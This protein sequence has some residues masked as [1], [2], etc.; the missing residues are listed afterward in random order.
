M[1]CAIISFI[2]YSW[3]KTFP[4]FII[5]VCAN[6]FI[7]MYFEIKHVS[8]ENIYQLLSVKMFYVEFIFLSFHSFKNDWIL[9][10]QE[11]FVGENSGRKKRKETLQQIT[12]RHYYDSFSIFF[13]A[14]NRISSEKL[15]M[16]NSVHDFPCTIFRCWQKCQKTRICLWKAY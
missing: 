12:N 2:T 15:T 6:A 16:Y 5:F 11:S 14:N 9:M 8:T 7:R 13:I 1:R 4:T 3:R 10:E